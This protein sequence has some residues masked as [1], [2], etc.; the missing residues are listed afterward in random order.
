SPEQ[1]LASLTRKY[2]PAVPLEEGT[3]LVVIID[4]KQAESWKNI[5]AQLR[6]GLSPKLEFGV[7]DEAKL[8]SLLKDSF[9]VE[10]DCICEGNVGDL[11]HAI[12]SAEG[13]HAFEETWAGDNLQSTLTWHYGFWEL[14]RLRQQCGKTSSTMLPPGRY[15]KVVTVMADLCGFSGYVKETK[16]DGVIRH[17]LSMFYSKARS[18]IL[19]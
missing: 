2:G 4:A 14:K 7:W 18:A 12:D 3:K 1:S 17:C 6:S 10:V 5:E 19:N 16:E 9:G 13:R 15:P 11:R 8:L